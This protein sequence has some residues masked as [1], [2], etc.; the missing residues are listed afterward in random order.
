MPKAEFGT[1]KWMSNKIKASGL[2]KLRWYCQMCQKQCRDENGFKC[3]RMSEGHQRAMQLFI[4][5][6]GHFMDEFSR[7][8]EEE[9]MK[10]MKTRY[11]RTRVLAN[12]VY[13]NVVCDRHHIHMNSTI[14]V[15]LSEFVQYLGATEKCKIEYTPK[16]WYVEYIDHEELARKKELEKKRKIEKSQE[17]ARMEQI[18]ALVEEARQRGGF[19]KPEY[20]PLQREDGQ[21]VTLSISKP[22]E[23]ADKKANALQLLHEKL[24]QERQSK[25]RGLPEKRKLS[26][27]EALV[28]E[29][30]CQKK[31]TAVFE[32]SPP[33]KE[34]SSSATADNDSRE[35][36]NSD[37]HASSWLRPPAHKHAGA[38][39]WIR[40]SL[41]V[42]VVHKTL[43][44]GTYYKQKGVVKA[45]D[46]RY[47]AVLEMLEGG[48]ILKLDQEYLETVIPAIGGRVA[49]V[50]GEWRGHE[51]RLEA[52]NIDSYSVRVTLDTGPLFKLDKYRG[53][54]GVAVEGLPYEHVC[55][56]EVR[57]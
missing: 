12:S 9:F 57:K 32:G 8:F 37:T 47:S 14:W 53:N 56:L 18:Q 29:A 16:G 26:E 33:L 23:S 1:P 34:R 35:Q 11:C 50:L 27:M 55:K 22:R 40:P 7:E 48:A 17:E 52:L 36:R 54:S 21:T 39:W 15:T 20:T 41:I 24:K 10:L 49:V 38:D 46:G 31:K 30:E 28:A 13:N 4:Q 25:S 6:P 42:K 45:V 5:R 2:Q 43:G 44:D 19:Q 51:G 3:H